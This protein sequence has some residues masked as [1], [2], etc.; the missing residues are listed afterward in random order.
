MT[1]MDSRHHIH[2]L[3][4]LWCSPFKTTG[5]AARRRVFDPDSVFTSSGGTSIL[6]V[7]RGD[8]LKSSRVKILSQIVISTVASS[9]TDNRVYPVASCAG[10]RKKYYLP[11]DL[12][13]PFIP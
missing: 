13:Y 3:E 4:P 8:R 2:M 1:K 7:R 10:Q 6:S 9:Q 12:Y 5:A 11:T